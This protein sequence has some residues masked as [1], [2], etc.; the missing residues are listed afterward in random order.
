M[1]LK[2]L[3]QKETIY[4]KS[5][6][7]FHNGKFMKGSIVKSNLSEN[8]IM[9]SLELKGV[10]NLGDV[11]TIILEVDGELTV[12]YKEKFRSVA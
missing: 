2:S 9:K 5:Y 4:P 12:I 1:I 10:F 11:H 3:K 6:L 7:I 8:D